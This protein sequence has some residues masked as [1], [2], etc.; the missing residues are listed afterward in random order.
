ML[1]RREPNGNRAPVSSLST[2]S[3]PT[4]ANRTYGTGRPRSGVFPSAAAARTTSA[5][6]RAASQHSCNEA[7]VSRLR[8]ASR[9]AA[10]TRPNGRLAQTSSGK[11]IC[12]GRRPC[13]ARAARVLTVNTD[14]GTR[15]RSARRAPKHRDGRPRPVRSRNENAPSIRGRYTWLNYSRPRSPRVTRV[16]GTDHRFTPR[17]RT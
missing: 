14:P 4:D 10:I 9:L 1:S 8:A 15:C 2:A 16:R 17:S 3:E 13:Q 12:C 5:C 6:R 11:A 7:R